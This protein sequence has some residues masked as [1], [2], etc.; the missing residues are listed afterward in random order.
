MFY[1]IYWHY[2]HSCPEGYRHFTPTK[3]KTLANFSITRFVPKLMTFLQN[4]HAE[5]REYEALG[6]DVWIVSSVRRS[7]VPKTW[8]D[9]YIRIMYAIN[10]FLSYVSYGLINTSVCN[11]LFTEY[12]N[13]S[14]FIR[15]A[16]LMVTI[17]RCSFVRM[18][19]LR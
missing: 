10:V 16:D 7:K 6:L 4:R 2:L 1:C 15:Y 5:T 14:S 18:Y 3:Q 12:L 11:E 19:W 17:P 8:L 9:M 13:Y